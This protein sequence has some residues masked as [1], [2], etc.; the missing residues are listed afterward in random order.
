MNSC[1]K[2]NDDGYTSCGAFSKVVTVYRDF[3]PGKPYFIRNSWNNLVD[4]HPGLVDL[5]RSAGHRSTATACGT[6]TRSSSSSGS[7]PR[8]F[9]GP[10][11]IRSAHSNLYLTVTIASTAANAT[12][13]QQPSKSGDEQR[14]YMTAVHGNTYLIDNVK[15]HMLLGNNGNGA[16]GAPVLQTAPWNGN[17][18]TARQ[19]WRLELSH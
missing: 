18:T 4:R 6:T 15:S 5:R 2:V 19:S 1:S 12:I 8:R 7:A 11:R 3:D 9:E 10:F 13:T 14:F 16:A 17:G